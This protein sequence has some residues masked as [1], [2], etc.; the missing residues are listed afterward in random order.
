MISFQIYQKPVNGLRENADTP[1]FLHIGF[2]VD[3]IQALFC[4][5]NA[6]H[7]D[8]FAG[9]G[10]ENDFLQAVLGHQIPIIPKGLGGHV[11]GLV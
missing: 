10:L 5:I 11:C 8:Q 9:D 7:I 6:K 2:N 3:R 4:G 1:Q